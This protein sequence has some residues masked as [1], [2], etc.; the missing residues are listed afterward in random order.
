[1]KIAVN[2]P[3]LH[4]PWHDAHA[5]EVALLI[6]KDLHATGILK[7][8][9]I[10]GDMLDF[11]DASLHEK[12]PWS[13]PIK[14]TIKDEVYV[15]NKFLDLLQELFPETEIVY[16]EGNHE[17]RLMRYIVKKCKELFDFFSVPELLKLEER[18]IKFLPY[19]RGQLGRVLD[20]NL[21]T[22]HAPYSQGINCA[23]S[24][25]QK[26]HRSLLF[27]HTHRVQSTTIKTADGQFLSAFSGGCLIDFN[28]PVFGYAD[29][30]DWAHSILVTYAWDK[31][32]WI[33]HQVPITNGKAV[34]NG[35]EY[36]SNEGI[37]L[38]GEEEFK[39]FKI[40]S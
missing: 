22:R 14:T 33:T 13:W 10:M 7:Q 3:D 6:M 40:A 2:L 34:Y 5:V 1:M 9:N 12:M 32:D 26:K 27:G 15:G 29:T 39:A 16:Y 36:Q 20:T 28:A 35:Y 31:D 8:I 37:K 11:C 21:Y 23:M 4:L 18:G 38:G 24:T 17:I 30:D 19:G 25:I